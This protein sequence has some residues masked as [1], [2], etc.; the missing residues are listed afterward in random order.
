MYQF[1]RWLGIELDVVSQREKFV[2]L[3]GGVL[4]I[5]ALIFIVNELCGLP[6]GTGLVASMGASAVL[7]FAVPHGQLSQPWPVVAGHTVSA[8]IGVTCARF[9]PGPTLAAGCAV[10]LSIWVMHQLKCIHPPGGATAL[11]AVLGGEVVHDLGYLFVL[12]PVL[13]NAVIMVSLA[14]VINYGFEWRRYPVGLGKDCRGQSEAA[15]E[16]VFSHEHIL[17]A[18]RQLDLFVD[19]AED[20]LLK[21]IQAFNSGDVQLSELQSGNEESAANAS[22][23]IQNDQSFEEVDDSQGDIGPKTAPENEPE[24]TE[25][26]SVR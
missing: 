18:L 6:L 10:G 9:L 26:A 16:L 25:L 11:V 12:A 4:A 24:E 22:D 1:I 3:L 20:D 2:S 23:S 13:A 19:V 17:R 5:S 15:E 7:L 14:V 8:L 21:L